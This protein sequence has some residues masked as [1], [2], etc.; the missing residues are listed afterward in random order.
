M[1]TLYLNNCEEIIILNLS[2]DSKISSSKIFLL[3]KIDKEYHTIY[4]I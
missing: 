1:W 3:Y 4:Y 2:K